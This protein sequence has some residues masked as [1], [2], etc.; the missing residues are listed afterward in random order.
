MNGH[1]TVWDLCSKQ[2]VHVFKAHDKAVIGLY[3]SDAEQVLFSA[4]EDKTFKVWAFDSI[5]LDEGRFIDPSKV[6]K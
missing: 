5:W 1:I 2:P 4:G 3:W 6:K